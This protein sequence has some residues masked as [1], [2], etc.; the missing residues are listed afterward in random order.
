MA[1]LYGIKRDNFYGSI[2]QRIEIEY[3]KRTTQLCR[4]EFYDNNKTR[5]M[6]CGMESSN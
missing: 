3:D 4:L 1:K 6:V 5:I 2:I